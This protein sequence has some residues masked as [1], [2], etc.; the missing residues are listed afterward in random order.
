MVGGSGDARDQQVRGSLDIPISL[1]RTNIDDKIGNK[2]RG[3]EGLLLLLNIYEDM[4]KK[5]MSSNP[6]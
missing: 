1:M 4:S 3:F 2:E 6:N 5:I